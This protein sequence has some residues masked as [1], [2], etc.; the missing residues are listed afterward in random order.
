[1]KLKSYLDIMIDSIHCS[2]NLDQNSY[3]FL[4]G[5]A[6]NKL[7]HNFLNPDFLK[8]FDELIGPKGVRGLQNGN[9]C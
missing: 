4:K 1:M 8:M 3:S 6:T 7:D 5:E 2:E 9:N